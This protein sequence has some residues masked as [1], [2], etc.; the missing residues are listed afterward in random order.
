MR[1][2]AALMAVALPAMAQEP[3]A[4]MHRIPPPTSTPERAPLP[5]EPRAAAVLSGLDTFSGQVTRFTVAVGG[6]AV[7]ERLLVRVLACHAVIG[8]EDAYAFLQIEDLKTPGRA[9]FRG[10]MVASAP[11]LSSLDHPRYD[12]WL[13]SCSTVSG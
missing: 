12:V 2:L 6:E 5:T 9:V 1:L 3:P 11:A 8:G 4:R 10:W 13:Q 7:Y